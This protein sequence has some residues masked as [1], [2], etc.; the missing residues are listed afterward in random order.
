MERTNTNSFSLASV[1]S[2]ES[3][4]TTCTSNVKVTFQIGS[5]ENDNTRDFNSKYKFDKTNEGNFDGIDK[6]KRVSFKEKVD[7]LMTEN[8]LWDDL[9]KNHKENE[10]KDFAS[11]A[12][13]LLKKSSI[14]AV[15]QM[16][17]ARSPYRKMLWMLVLFAGLFGCC[18]QIYRFCTLYFQYPVVVNLHVENKWSLEFPA[19]TICNLNRMK[20]DYEECME[21]NK[22]ADNCQ[23]PTMVGSAHK[24]KISE[25]RI[26]ASCSNLLSGLK[27]KNLHDRIKF[28]TKYSQMDP[29]SRKNFGHQLRDFIVNC[30][31]ND[32]PCYEDNF[33]YFQN[34][35]YGNCYTFNKRE[36]NS[37]TILNTS[38]VGIMSG[39]DIILDLDPE[40][41]LHTTN[42][43]GARIIIHNS[44]EDPN[45]EEE[46]L[47]I[48]PGFETS[49]AIKQSCIRRLPAPYKDRCIYY[50]T[51]K[52]VRGN[53]QD[54]C[55]RSC[56]QELNQARCLC[57]DPTL[58]PF[59]DYK[60]CNM[61]NAT[62][63]CCLDNVLEHLAI[64][65]LPCECP[66]P[67]FSTR[68]D[69]RM[70]SAIWPP[71]FSNSKAFHDCIDA[72]CFQDL[73]KRQA[74]LKI[75][76]ASLEQTTYEQ[77]A[78]FQDSELFSHL[79]GQLGLWLGLSI[80]AAFELIENM[81]Y[82]GKYCT[83]LICR[84][85]NQQQ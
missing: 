84:S 34:L 21:K 23:T 28:L 7:E 76:Y 3:G 69:L 35:K 8:Y 51:E 64:H 10:M 80:V 65:G 40:M 53:N 45:P 63:A 61:T 38:F 52:S 9:R 1:G 42:S 16:G 31:F 54:D 30:S 20:R 50:G 17:Q 75:Y 81:I 6:I 49:L 19:V 66:L 46:G 39:L 73:R 4:G 62:T 36:N 11:V 44:S 58:P 72:G 26:V 32:E 24:I 37:D 48:S 27:D 57:I 29:E 85:K 79:G 78:M 59:E 56:I 67:C 18:L 5:E 33:S 15:S 82:V 41:Y 2:S 55:I 25:R 60:Q 14:Y 74:K 77:K 83:T 12:K 13:H 71:I 70:S 22:T 68:Y 47:N 43:I